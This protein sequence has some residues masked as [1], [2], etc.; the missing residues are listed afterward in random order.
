MKALVK[1]LTVLFCLS[2]SVPAYSGD[3]LSFL[4]KRFTTNSGY[5]LNYRVLYPANYEPGKQYPLILFLHGSGERGND[6]EAQLVHGGDLLAS[7]ENRTNYPAIVIVPQCPAESSWVDYKRPR[8]EGEKRFF[9]P[10]NTI[11]KP[12][13]AVKDLID[14]Y[15]SK[16]I[17]DKNNMHIAGLSMGGMGTFDFVFR[18]PNLFVT[19]TPICGGA[20]IQRAEQF[21]GKT[22]FRIFHGQDDSTV[23]PQYSRDVYA[24]LQKAGAKVSY[25]EYPGVKHNSWDN[26]F[27]EPDF[28]S[29]MLS[30]K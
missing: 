2:L 13:G 27:A 11:S 19:A 20:N 5:E 22:I 25:K 15:I 10:A 1:T 28:I 30:Q 18:Y 3:K 8:A 26:A 24:A 6:N 29:W 14:S 4:K 16:G 7:N 17:V 12:L 23:D 21:R 9:Y